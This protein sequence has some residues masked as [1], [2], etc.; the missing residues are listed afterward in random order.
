MVRFDDSLRRLAAGT[1]GA[2]CVLILGTGP[3]LAADRTVPTNLPGVRAYP[4]P[5]AG[6]DPLTATAAALEEAGLPPRPDAQANPGGYRHWLR[7]VTAPAT[8]II[9]VLEPTNIVHHP[10]QTVGPVAQA[11]PSKST[12][13]S[14]YIVT[15]PSVTSYSKS[16]FGLIG[17]EFVVP[18]VEQALKTCGEEVF[19]SEWVGID[20]IN[21]DTALIQAGVNGSS[22]CKNG[23]QS[24]SYQTWFEWFPVPSVNIKN[25]PTNPGEDYEVYVESVSATKAKAYLMNYVENVSA[26]ISFSAPKGSAVIGNSAEWILEAPTINGGQ[27][28]LANYSVDYFAWDEAETF[29]KKYAYPGYPGSGMQAIQSE[30]IN[31]SGTVVSIPEL[32]GP[33]SI[34]LYATGPAR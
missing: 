28:A 34:F 22:S 23:N 29:S 3:G 7:F 32:T 21:K 30:M 8:R 33:A 31:Q 5:P 17:G 25:F 1:A 13:W 12:N 14:G 4:A 27:S 6:F 11:G 20:G 24:L 18:W 19:A 15:I 26:T 2:C 10:W 16:S 9:P